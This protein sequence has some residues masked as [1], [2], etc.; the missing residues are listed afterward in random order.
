MGTLTEEYE[1]LLNETDRWCYYGNMYFPQLKYSCE[2]TLFNCPE[3]AYEFIEWYFEIGGKSSVL[4]LNSRKL[5]SMLSRER[6]THVVSTFFLG[7]YVAEA[8]DIKTNLRDSENM[9]FRYYWFLMALFHD[10]GYDYE[11]KSSCSQKDIIKTRG[12]KGLKN[13]LRIKKVDDTVFQTYTKTEVESYLKYRATCTE[14]NLGKIDHGIAGGLLIYDR[15]D[16]MFTTS[17]EHCSKTEDTTHQSFY[18]YIRT[19]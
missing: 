5:K 15:L 19:M 14:E 8:F 18:F 4:G 10:M 16:K 9:D 6:A 1:Q 3:K 12:L 13:V 2:R 11:M 7:I 17:W